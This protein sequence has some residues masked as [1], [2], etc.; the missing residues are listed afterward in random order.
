MQAIAKFARQL[1]IDPPSNAVEE[2]IDKPFDGELTYGDAH[3]VLRALARR[4][5]RNWNN[6]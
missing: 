4:C 5:G 3:F 6:K 2:L 1:G